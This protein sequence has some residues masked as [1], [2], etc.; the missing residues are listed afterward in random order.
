M[1]GRSIR[2]KRRPKIYAD[3]LKDMLTD[4]LAMGKALHERFIVDDDFMPDHPEREQM[5]QYLKAKSWRGN[6]SGAAM[7]A[8]VS[9][10]KVIKEW[11]QYEEFVEMEQFA[12]Q[13]CT[14]LVEETGLFKVYS[15]NDK[16]LIRDHLKGRKRYT[17][18][19][20]VSGPDGAPLSFEINLT[21]I[22][23]PRRLGDSE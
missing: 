1:P 16:S 3:E 2:A 15:S 23:R 21:G 18:R 7:T 4:A 5:V 17:D 8:G 22:P 10:R 11:R 12:D 14:D 20:E 13:A 6:V 19:Q 9:M